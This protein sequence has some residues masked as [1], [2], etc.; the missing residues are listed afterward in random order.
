[1]INPSQCCIKSFVDASNDSPKSDPYVGHDHYSYVT[2]V[3]S[4]LKS[5]TTRL[6]VQHLDRAYNNDNIKAPYYHDYWLFVRGI[7]WSPVAYPHKG[8]VMRQ[9][10]PCN[11]LIMIPMNDIYLRGGSLISAAVHYPPWWW[12]FVISFPGEIGVST[13]MCI[14]KSLSPAWSD[15]NVL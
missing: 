2:W 7:H 11:G 14:Y 4:R 15:K 3:S 10:F 9:T 12:G 1:M 6:F 8:P 13:V 5:R